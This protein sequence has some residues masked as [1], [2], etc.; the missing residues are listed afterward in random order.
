MLGY[1]MNGHI[2]A[3]QSTAIIDGFSA[4]DI[5]VIE[6]DKE[7]QGTVARRLNEQ[8]YREWL[9]EYTLSELWNKNVIGG[10]PV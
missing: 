4:N 2:V 5:T 10:R 7:I 8:E 3:T 1:M 9:D 6:R